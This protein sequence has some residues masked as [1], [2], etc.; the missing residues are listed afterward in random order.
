MLFPSSSKTLNIGKH[1]MNSEDKSTPKS[2]MSLFSDEA[3]KTWS[4]GWDQMMH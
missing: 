2:S 3:A 1:L 4:F